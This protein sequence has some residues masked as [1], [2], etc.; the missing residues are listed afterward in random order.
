V[1][2]HPVGATILVN[3]LAEQ[4]P[5]GIGAIVLIAVPFIGEGGVGKA[6]TTFTPAAP[7]EPT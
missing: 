2:G 7:G 3:A 1:V 4:P 6:G 5:R